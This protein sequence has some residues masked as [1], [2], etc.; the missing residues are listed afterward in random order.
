ML[1]LDEEKAKNIGREKE[2]HFLTLRRPV[3]S[4]DIKILNI[5]EPNNRFSK[6]M[7]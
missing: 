6:Y 2:G 7:K 3:P 5:D 4:E 1:I